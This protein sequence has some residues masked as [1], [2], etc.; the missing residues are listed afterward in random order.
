MKVKNNDLWKK[1]WVTW[2]K[3]EEEVEQIFEKEEGKHCDNQI[4]KGER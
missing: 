1:M 4:E 3:K 2:K